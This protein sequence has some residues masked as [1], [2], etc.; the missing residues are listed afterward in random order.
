MKSPKSSKA[1]RKNKNS[2]Q[3]K[4]LIIELACPVFAFPLHEIKLYANCSYSE[5]GL[6]I[7]LCS[8]VIFYDIFLCWYIPIM[9]FILIITLF[10]WVLMTWNLDDCFYRVWNCIHNNCVFSNKGRVKSFALNW[11][12]PLIWDEVCATSL[13]I[14]MLMI[15]DLVCHI[16]REQIRHVI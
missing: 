9:L 3:M 10:M 1:R 11:T 4:R 2:G 15:H 5:P 13:G 8:Q 12:F 6:A 7:L 16:K 14:M